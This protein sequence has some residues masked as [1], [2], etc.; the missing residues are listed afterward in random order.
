[1]RSKDW[2]ARL[3]LHNFRVEEARRQVGEI[4]MMISEFRR[5][6]EELEAGITFE[7]KKAGVNDPSHVRYPPAAIDMR[8]RRDNL[9]RSITD[10]DGQLAAAVQRAEEAE[11]ELKKVELLVEKAAGD[12]LPPASGD[13]D[14]HP[15]IA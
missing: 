12:A 13:S 6:Q 15:R 10:L 5:K 2:Q 7:E 8:N 3:R 1:M 4:E 14:L 11:E 9:A